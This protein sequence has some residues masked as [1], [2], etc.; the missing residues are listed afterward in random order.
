MRGYID[1]EYLSYEDKM[2]II[3]AEFERWIQR[4]DSLSAEEAKKEAHEGLVKIGFI[5]N[6][7]NLTAPYIALQN[8]YV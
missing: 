5:D 8:R 3:A 1:M 4:L 2:N 7:G 6:E